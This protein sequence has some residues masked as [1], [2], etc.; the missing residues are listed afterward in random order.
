MKTIPGEFP[1]LGGAIDPPATKFRSKNAF[2]AI[3]VSSEY[4][5]SVDGCCEQNKF[6]IIEF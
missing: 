4:E 6:G 1:P 3:G 2:L 5:L